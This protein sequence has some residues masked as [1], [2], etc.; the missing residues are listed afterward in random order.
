MTAPRP[1]HPP[2]PE[3]PE[4]TPVWT[5]DLAHCDECNGNGRPV[6]TAD[7]WR[8]P[9]HSFGLGGTGVCPGSLRAV[10]P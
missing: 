10:T 3:P 5:G 6:M 4:G 7:G 1:M 8:V 2:R 9:V